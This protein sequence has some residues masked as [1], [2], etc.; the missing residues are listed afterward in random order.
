MVQDQWLKAVDFAR[1]GRRPHPPLR[2]DGLSGGQSCRDNI[3]IVEKGSD[4][5]TVGSKLEG[6]GLRGTG[7]A[8][9]LFKDCRGPASSVLGTEG[10]GFLIA[11]AVLDEARIGAAAAGAGIAGGTPARS[12]GAAK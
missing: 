6:M 3:L 9:L 12:V 4:G 5:F 10:D 1:Y 7:T 11:M 2:A 8:E